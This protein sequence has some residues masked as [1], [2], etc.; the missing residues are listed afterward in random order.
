MP[1]S[2]RGGTH[3]PEG[4]DRTAD[5][6]DRERVTEP[7]EEPDPRRAPDGRARLTIVPTA[8]TWSA[9]VAC[10]MPRKNPRTTTEKRRSI[11]RAALG[12]A[13]AAVTSGQGD[14]DP[15]ASLGFSMFATR[16]VVTLAGRWR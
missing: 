14:Q 1:S 13:S 5:H 3:E 10:R 9:S 12:F 8:I 15:A 4:D 2:S 6:E 7:P 16:R 11:M